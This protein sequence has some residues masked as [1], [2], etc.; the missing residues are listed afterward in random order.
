MPRV[1]GSLKG[2]VEA[3]RERPRRHA[4]L[5]VLETT[6]GGALKEDM[7]T[8]A[9]AKERRDLGPESEMEIM[10]PPGEQPSIKFALQVRQGLTAPLG[11]DEPTQPPPPQEPVTHGPGRA[12]RAGGAHEDR[13]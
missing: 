5:R 7:L 9:A 13:S 8:Y 6:I 12:A 2:R 10:A 1:A 3:A 11:E 4:A